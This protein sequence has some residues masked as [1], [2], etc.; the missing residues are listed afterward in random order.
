MQKGRQDGRG[1]SGRN[2]RSNI[3][4]GGAQEKKGRGG[5]D[6]TAQRVESGNSSGDHDSLTETVSATLAQSTSSRHRR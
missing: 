3:R 2:H 1:N 4:V 6:E 5:Q